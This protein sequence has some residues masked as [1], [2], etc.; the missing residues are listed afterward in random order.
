MI[1]VTIEAESKFALLPKLVM[2]S[3]KPERELVEIEF[4]SAKLIF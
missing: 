2:L 3:L 4:F 1:V